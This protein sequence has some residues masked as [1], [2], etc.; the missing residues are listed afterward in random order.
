[1]IW[2]TTLLVVIASG[3]SVAYG[4][5]VRTQTLK[6]EPDPKQLSCGQKV[7]VENNTCPAG[8]ILEVTGSCLEIRNSRLIRC[9]GGYNTTVSSG[10]RTKRAFPVS[11]DNTGNRASD[12]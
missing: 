11:D 9:K 1:M 3:A 12:N 2:L 10:N 5:P 6:N 4:A 7:L 8:Q